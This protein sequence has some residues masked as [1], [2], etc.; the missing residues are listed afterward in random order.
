Y[1]YS[2]PTQKPAFS[3]VRIAALKTW[4][5]RADLWERYTELRQNGKSTIGKDNTPVDPF[6]REAHRFYEANRE[7]M[8]AGAT[9]SNPYNFETDALPDGSPRHL[10]ALQ[11]LYDYIADKG[12]RSFL[13]R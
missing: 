4:P 3:G 8:D 13:T 5:D 11:K 10:S 6:G 9:L 12:M 2:D 1:K 7:A